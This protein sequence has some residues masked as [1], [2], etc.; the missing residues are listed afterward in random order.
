MICEAFACANRPK[1][2]SLVNF[3]NLSFKFTNFTAA[4][5]TLGKAFT[6]TALTRAEN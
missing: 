4:S 3:K 5:R 1:P 2:K 6:K